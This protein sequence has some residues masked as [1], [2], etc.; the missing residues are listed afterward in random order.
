MAN[1][2]KSISESDRRFII[3]QSAGRC[4][5]CR[6]ELFI[7]NEF[8][9]K[10]RLGDD[11]H[12]V[13]C[14]PR[15]PRGHH[16]RTEDQRASADNLI[17]LCKNCHAEVDQQ[18]EKHSTSM[19]LEIRQ[20]HYEWVKTS[21]GNKAISRP[22]FHY[23]SYINVPRVDMYAAVNSIALPR[24]DFG[25]A[26]SIRQLGLNAGRFMASYTAILNHEA[27]YANEID[28]STEFEALKV[29][30][31]HFVQPTNFRTRKILDQANLA[32]AWENLE[33]VI[34]RKFSAWQ[35]YCLIDPRWITTNTAYSNFRGGTMN[36]LGLIHLNAVDENQKKVTAS[37]LF[38][39]TP[40]FGFFG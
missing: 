23:L 3:G 6:K 31:Y 16:V 34:Y 29:G 39:G 11:A 5:K 30:S 4:S 18:P 27:L 14:S 7:E 10:A 33:S 13:A 24:V 32:S 21:L 8:G 12:I 40:D 36:T 26:N 35:L 22:R 19:L 1:H 15:G 28:C 38:L 20:R 37:P 2:R 17:L 25:A 9:E